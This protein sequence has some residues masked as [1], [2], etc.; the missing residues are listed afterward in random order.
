MAA[1]EVFSG[2]RRSVTVNG[3]E[4]GDWVTDWNPEAEDDIQEFQ[5]SNSSPKARNEAGR[6]L[7]LTFTV[8]NHPTP[9]GLIEPAYYNT[10]KTQLDIVSTDYAGREVTYT[11]RI[12]H[13]T[14]NGGSGDVLTVDVE[15]IVLSVSGIPGVS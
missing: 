1:P 15:T 4:I 9:M 13:L 3:T 14:Y 6:T 10:P 8:A 5:G 2:W 12:S 7:S 11:V